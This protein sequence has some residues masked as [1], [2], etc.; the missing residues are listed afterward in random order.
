MATTRKLDYRFSSHGMETV[1]PSASPKIQTYKGAY[2]SLTSNCNMNC[3][4]CYAKTQ[5]KGELSVENFRQIL[6]WLEEI[7]DFKKVNLVGGEPTMVP[8]LEQLLEAI[9]ARSWTATI[10]TNGIFG[11]EQCNL[12]KEHPGVSQIVFH[13]NTVFFSDSGNTKKIIAR[14]L[15]ELADTKECSFIFVISELDFDYTE[16]L[17]MAEKE[18][19]SLTWIFA[20]PTSGNSPY[21]GL[22]TMCQAGSKV[23]EFLIEA[24]KKGIMTA[25]DLSVPLCIFSEDFLNEYK[26]RFSL[27]KKC[28]PFI[29]F[30]PDM[31]TQSCTSMPCHCSKPLDN[32]DSLRKTIE[33]Y[34]EK[35]QVLK[36][37]VSF[38]ECI[39]CKYH[40][41]RTCQGGCMTY[42]MYASKEKEL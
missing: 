36:R 37:T 19:L 9:A 26:D 3:S 35:D 18:G 32:A 22:K 33:S 31:S 29:Y 12:L 17:S 20:T 1:F 2:I 13:Y 24:D 23:Q 8:H 42:K 25:P 7:S 11:S 41:D 27:V 5:P 14:N 30:L 34:R 4:Y 6:D 10:Y 21:M 28:M 39:D 15:S 38:P 16:P 40:L